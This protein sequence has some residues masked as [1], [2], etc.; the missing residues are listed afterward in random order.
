ME[1]DLSQIDTAVAYKLLTATVTPRPIAWVTTMDTEARINAAPYSFFN[2]MGS[3]PPIVALGALSDPARGFKDTVRNIMATGEFVVNLVPFALAEAMNLTAVD[4]PAGVDE[5]ALAKLE[6]RPSRMVTPPRI[7]Q[8]PVA[9]ECAM[10]SSIVTGPHQALIVGRVLS[11]HIDDAFVLDAA[12]GH[13]DTTSLDLIGRSFGSAYIRTRDR[14][15]MERPTWASL[16]AAAE[17]NAAPVPTLSK[18]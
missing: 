12:R 1:F 8:S 2:V 14:F 15:A 16:S 6:T 4:A 7:A 17:T 3:T 5:L 18:E 10:H 11:I 9:L 13:V